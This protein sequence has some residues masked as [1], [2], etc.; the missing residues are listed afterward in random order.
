MRV[1]QG[2]I[3]LGL[4]AVFAASACDKGPKPPPVIKDIRAVPRIFGAS[5]VA[6]NR[7]QGIRVKIYNTGS[8]VA[9]GGAVSSL[10]SW[11]ARVTL[12]IPAF[13]IRHP[14]EGLI[15]FD[16][17]LH[18]E[19]ET[20][21]KKKMGRINYFFIPF[22]AARG[23]NLA[24]QLKADGV[25]PEDVRWVVISHMHLDH[26][27]MIDAFP[28]AKVLMD[29]REWDALRAK[30]AAGT[31]EHYEE[32][33]DALESRINLKLVDVSSAPAFGAFDHA[34]DLFKDGSLFLVDMAGHTAGNMGLWV[35]L[36]SGP[37]LLAGDA[38]WILDNHQDFALPIEAH[39]YD[40][41]QYWR[42]LYMMR[43]MQN[44][45][46]RLVIYPGH[47]IRPVE[48]QPRPDIEIVPFPR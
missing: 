22:K 5:L 2:L 26:H 24:A 16:T 11:K 20:M 44:A 40:I 28:K 18:P 45:I 17:G 4:L 3:A 38:S 43:A 10:K 37:V 7:A 21:P 35:N 9:P 34:E 19:M 8:V 23:Q 31:L 30:K 29:R 1:R 47:D 27:G 41:R 32:D 15:L 33:P 46:P 6:K 36:D 12:D 48:Y 39:I 42:R 14:R 25:S 13:L